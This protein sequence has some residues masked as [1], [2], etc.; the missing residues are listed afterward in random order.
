MDFLKLFGV[1][2]RIKALLTLR[3]TCVET[4]NKVILDFLDLS[5]RR[6]CMYIHFDFYNSL[7]LC[8]WWIVVGIAGTLYRVRHLFL[9]WHIVLV[10]WP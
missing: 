7:D 10:E 6:G 8:A 4:N 5:P 9:T 3:Y 2:P 1:T